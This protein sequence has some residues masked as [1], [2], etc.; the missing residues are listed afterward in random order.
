MPVIAHAWPFPFTARL[1]SLVLLTFSSVSKLSA[2]TIEIKLIDGRNG[3]TIENTCVN[4]WVGDER[5][6]PLAIPIDNSGV[7]R[8]RLTGSDAE[9][10]TNESWKSCGE[11]GVINPVVKY[12]DVIKVNVGYVVCEPHGTDYSWLAVKNVSTN[13]LVQKGIVT[14]NTC[15]KATASPTPGE[16]IIFVRPLNFWEKLKQ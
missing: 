14:A 7:A 11:F 5:K 2:Q 4:V 8:L 1:L 6:Y 9:L 10:N 3:H 15:G 12:N 16:L 13:Q